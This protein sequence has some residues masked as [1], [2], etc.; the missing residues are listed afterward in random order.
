MKRPILIIIPLAIFGGCYSPDPLDI[1][2]LVIREGQHRAQPY[3]FSWNDDK[4]LVYEW[5]PNKSMEYNLDGIDQCDWNKLT[6]YS[7]DLLSNHKNSLMVAWRYDLAGKFLFAPYY[8]ENGEAHK[9]EP[10]CTGFFY[11]PGDLPV[12]AANISDVVETHIIV[13]RDLRY[14]AIFI[15]NRSTGDQVFWENY[16]DTRIGNVREIGPW[17]GGNEPAPHDIFLYRRLL[18]RQ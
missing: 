16:W 7:F 2:R 4:L 17:F 18:D 5:H 6:G 15:I 10:S 3:G 12:L 14:T 9:L 1:E 13:N 11:N 8:H